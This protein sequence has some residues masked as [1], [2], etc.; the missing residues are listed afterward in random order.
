MKTIFENWKAYIHEAKI[1][2]NV[3]PDDKVFLT[4]KEY[5]GFQSVSQ[6]EPHMT[7]PKPNGLW[8]ACGKEWLKFGVKGG[9]YLY[10]IDIDYS[11][12]LRIT[13]K[14]VKKFEK[15]FGTSQEGVPLVLIDWKKVAQKYS[16][17]EICPYMPKIRDHYW[18]YGWDVASGCIWEASA[19]K[20]VTLID[21]TTPSKK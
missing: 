1:G 9:T 21:N 11:K 12:M 7:N 3:G 4:S 16:G 6:E 8:Y 20:D 13:Q 5:N 14:D 17:I 10:K 2:Q 19:I 18:Y 15:E